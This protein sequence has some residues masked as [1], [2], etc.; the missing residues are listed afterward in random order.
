MLTLLQTGKRDIVPL[1]L[2][3]A[4]G[5]DYWSFFH[6]FVVNRLL[7]DGLIS[8]QDLSLY[9]LTDDLAVA[10]NEVL[11][12]YRTY[13]GMRYVRRKLS[14]RLSHPLSDAM[15]QR[16]NHDFRDILQQGDFLQRG[17]LPRATNRPSVSIS[18][19]LV[20][21]FDRRSQGRLRELIDTINGTE[22]A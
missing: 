18:R 11:N 17:P 20:F 2:L 19:P 4:P 21:H 6:D 1:I 15:L 14:I 13:Q 9:R 16:L 7:R 8:R 3:D 12:F 22:T 5:G 10:V